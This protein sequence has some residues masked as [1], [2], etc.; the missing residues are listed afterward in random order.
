MKDHDLIECLA[1]FT[2][3]DVLIQVD[4]A[5]ILAVDVDCDRKDREQG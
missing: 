4:R 2:M 3:V 5:R 1:M